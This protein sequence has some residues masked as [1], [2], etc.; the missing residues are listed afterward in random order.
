LSQEAEL[1]FNEVIKLNPNTTNIY[2]SLAILYRKEMEYEKAIQTYN[3]ALKVD[4]EDE[5]ILFNL[6]R[7]YFDAEEYQK[8]RDVFR[9]AHEI[10]PEFHEAELMYGKTVKVLKEKQAEEKEKGK[11]A[12]LFLPHGK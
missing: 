11:Y 4:P 2:N 3:K 7:A 6:G 8:A 5:N 12:D 10:Y 9:K 1:A